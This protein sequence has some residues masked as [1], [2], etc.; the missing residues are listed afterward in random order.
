MPHD[1]VQ[2]LFAFGIVAG[3][4]AKGVGLGAVGNVFVNAQA[5]LFLREEEFPIGLGE[6]VGN[7]VEIEDAPLLELAA[8][9]PGALVGVG[10]SLPSARML[11]IGHVNLRHAVLLQTSMTELD[12]NDST[13]QKFGSFNML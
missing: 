8:I 9:F 3:G 13:V 4:A 6:I 7:A 10:D 11:V 2:L 5:A 1:I 12:N